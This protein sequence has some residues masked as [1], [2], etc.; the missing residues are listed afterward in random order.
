[1]IKLRKSHDRGRAEYGW[2]V[3]R[4]TFSF[5]RYYDPEY[6]GF[7]SLRV[8]NEDKVAPGGGF[9]THPHADMEII[10][11][12]ISGALE[13]RDSM[14]N[15]SVIRAGDV[16]KMSAGKGITHS[17]FNP[18]DS[19]TG[20]FYQIWLT[21]SRKGIEPMYAQISISRD[22]KVGKLFLIA[23]PD[24]APIPLV[25]DANIFCSILLEGDALEYEIGTE[26]HAWVQIISGQ[27]ELNG[28]HLKEG[29]GAAISDEPALC[30]SAISECEFMLFDLA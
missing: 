26:R 19:E 13:H 2:L 25:Q 11:F 1:M 18:S 3:T 15:G 20:H 24:G 30:L 29:D 27:M 22:D 28:T 17:E 4:H 16:Q 8:I 6:L 12:V 23:A 10:T 7:R 21:P 9:P 5:N 14:G